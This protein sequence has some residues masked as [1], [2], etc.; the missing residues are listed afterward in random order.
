MEVQTIQRRAW[1]DERELNGIGSRDE[2]EREEKE[3]GAK[4]VEGRKWE[5][6]FDRYEPQA[7]ALEEGAHPL[8]EKALE[9]DPEN[10]SAPSEKPEKEKAEK[11]TANTDKVD[12]EIEK[13]KKKKEQLE[14]KIVSEK[15][16]K[17][18]EKLENEL[19]QVEAELSQKDNEGYRRRHTH[20][21]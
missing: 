15:D 2:G 4:A 3:A 6:D 14:Q 13:L 12:R 20:F 7:K 8:K 10:K 21:S 5:P 17:K 19:A 16:E 18:R 9:E 11:C 1:Q